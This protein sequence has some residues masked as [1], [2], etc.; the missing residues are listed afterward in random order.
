VKSTAT[1]HYHQEKKVKRVRSSCSHILDSLSVC[2]TGWRAVLL[3]FFSLPSF[4]SLSC[5]TDCLLLELHTLIH[6]FFFSFTHSFIHSFTSSYF[7]L[8]LQPTN[9]RDVWKRSSLNVNYFISYNM[10]VVCSS[11]WFSFLFFEYDNLTDF[12]NRLKG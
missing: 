12:F 2:L 8:S 1:T 4:F 6:T 5:Y 10:T 7:N 9:T 3:Q 11:V